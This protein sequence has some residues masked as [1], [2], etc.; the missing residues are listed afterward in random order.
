MTTSHLKSDIRAVFFQ[1]YRLTGDFSYARRLAIDL[2]LLGMPPEEK[3][4]GVTYIP[5]PKDLS[6]IPYKLR[7]LVFPTAQKRQL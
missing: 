2:V 6:L 3:A 7:R 1:A 4:R 5:G